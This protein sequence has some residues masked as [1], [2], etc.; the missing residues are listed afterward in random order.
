MSAAGTG[1]GR[2]LDAQRKCPG[3]GREGKVFPTHAYNLSTLEVDRRTINWMPT[4]TILN[5]GVAWA[6]WQVFGVGG[7]RERWKDRDRLTEREL[8]D[9]PDL[10]LRIPAPSQ[11]GEN[12]C[13]NFLLLL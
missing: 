5:L 10:W 11:E 4:W 13:F 2:S 9:W 7:K 12:L 1:Q 8:R 6:T 3:R